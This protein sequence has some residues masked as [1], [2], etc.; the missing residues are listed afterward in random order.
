MEDTGTTPSIIKDHSYSKSQSD[1]NVEE[2]D[3]EYEYSDCAT[4]FFDQLE[5]N[6]DDTSLTYINNM[7]KQVG[8]VCNIEKSI[9]FESDP[10]KLV[11]R[12]WFLEA[13]TEL[14]EKCPA[15]LHVLVSAIG[16]FSCA[17]R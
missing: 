8:N 7:K 13:A 16:M 5:F 15:L 11:K 1:V 12:N 2:N 6:N 9:L 4:K 10:Q 14:K 17:F 3:K